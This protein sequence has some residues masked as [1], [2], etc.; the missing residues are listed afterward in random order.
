MS[1]S[2]NNNL[3]IAYRY[4]LVGMKKICIF[5]LLLLILPAYS[6]SLQPTWTAPDTIV[7][8]LP[9]MEN[10]SGFFGSIPTLM[11]QFSFAT[12]RNLTM[13]LVVTTGKVYMLYEQDPPWMEEALLEFYQLNNI[14]VDG[15]ALQHFL[16]HIQTLPEEFSQS[17][18]LLLYALN[19][20]TRSSRFALRN[21]TPEELQFLHEYN[22]S[23]TNIT[24]VLRY[25]ISERINIFPNLN[26]FV[27]ES[28]KLS[29]II[30]KIDRAALIDG[31]LGMLSAT[32]VALPVL[33]QYAAEYSNDHILT[34]PSNYIRVGGS[35]DS[36]HTGTYALLVDLGG[37]DLLTV[38]TD[39]EMAS[40]TLN[41]A[42]HD[43]YQGKIANTFASINL[44]CDL[45]GNDYYSGN[46]WSQAYA[47]AGLA[48]LLDINGNDVYAGGSHVQG[49]A[50]AGGISILA[51]LR[52]NDT[53]H[54]ESYSQGC[55]NGVSLGILADGIGN[56]IYS[57]KNRSQGYGSNG[58]LGLLVDFLGTDVYNAG[59]YSQGVGEGWANGLKR[60][61][62]GTL[63]DGAGNDVYTAD[64]YAQGFG[65]FV[66]IGFMADFFGSDHYTAGVS[67]Q[68]SSELFGIACL[69][70]MHGINDYNRGTHSG[71]YEGT[72]GTAVLVDGIG[73]TF[74]QKLWNI[75]Q[76]MT[77]Y[78]ITPFSLLFRGIIG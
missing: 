62:I 5:L 36:I 28:D 34:D 29:L 61:G 71:G 63:L 65:K 32:R 59:Q 56:D 58:G 37:N 6:T 18:A 14:T 68:A 50:H 52:G 33:Q 70:D 23:E 25:T 54:A 73:S 51:D 12:L 76:S 64:C 39:D 40:L 21:L 9:T 67:S 66:G 27:S 48:T 38:H 74:N 2:K 1:K 10:L 8:E 45:Q 20:G 69:I 30:Q 75:L 35:A 31:G 22:E 15:D 78:D 55:A 24:D 72:W 43:R 49:V 47:C 42:G 19:D 60:L 3:L 26:F 44:V 11:N 46:N 16:H 57:A 13:E 7:K 53:Y 77:E 41:I 4:L 17:I